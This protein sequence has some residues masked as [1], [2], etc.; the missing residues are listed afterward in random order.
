MLAVRLG[1][2]VSGPSHLPPDTQRGPGMLWKLPVWIIDIIV[3]TKPTYV[4]WKGFCVQTDRLKEDQ[5]PFA[6]CI[7][8]V[9]YT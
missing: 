7:F 2:W 1:G 4:C 5:C 3:A 9:F 6:F 8:L